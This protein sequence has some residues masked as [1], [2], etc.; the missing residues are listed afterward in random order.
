MTLF[1]Q[2]T[3]ILSVFIVLVL[4]SIMYLNFKTANDFIQN[5]LYTTSEDTATSL[6]LSLSLQIPEDSD[7]LSTMETMISAFLIEGIMKISPLRIMMETS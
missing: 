2:I 4:S 1:K 3:I 5:Q 7:D 6:G